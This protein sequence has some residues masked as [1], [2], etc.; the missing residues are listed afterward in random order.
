MQRQYRIGEEF[1]SHV[2]VLR[3]IAPLGLGLVL[4]LGLLVPPDPDERVSFV[5]L[6]FLCAAVLWFSYWLHSVVQAV[7]EVDAE[8][9]SFIRGGERTRIF[10]ADVVDVRYRRFAQRLK[11]YSRNGAVINVEKQLAGFEEVAAEIA[12]RTG[13]APFPGRPAAVRTGS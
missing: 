13:R 8:G 7:I 9:L 3:W 11:V 6:V 4:L 1:Q 10:W 5:G 12:Q 2:R